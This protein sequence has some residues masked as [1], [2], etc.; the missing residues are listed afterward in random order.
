[1]DYV[2]IF[3]AIQD[4]GLEIYASQDSQSSV[5][6]LPSIY[7]TILVHRYVFTR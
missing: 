1:M 7:Q 6:I 3:Q 5:R 4:G 2:C